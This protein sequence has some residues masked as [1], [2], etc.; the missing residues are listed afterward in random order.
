MVNVFTRSL[1]D[2]LASLVKQIDETASS[3]K[4]LRGFVVLLADDGD[5]AESKLKDFAKKHNIKNI[6][7]T[8]IEGAGPSN[9]K[10]AKNADVTVHLWV[11]TKVKANHAF[12]KLDQDGV[13]AVVADLPKILN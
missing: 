6:P 13:K 10:I 9:Y 4:S 3:N 8:Y 12:E 1:S 5:E 7:L 11:K 2:D